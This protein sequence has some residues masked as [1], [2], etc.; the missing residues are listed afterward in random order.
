M[1]AQTLPPLPRLPRASTF[2]GILMAAL[3]QGIRALTVG[4]SSRSENIV[5]PL[6]VTSLSRQCL[7][8]MGRR[9][10]AIAG[11]RTIVR[12]MERHHE[13]AYRCSRVGHRACQPDLRSDRQQ[14]E[15]WRLRL[16][17]KLPLLWFQ[18]IT[19]FGR[20]LRFKPPRWLDDAAGPAAG[21]IVTKSIIAG[22]EGKLCCARVTLAGRH[23][24]IC[25][26][27]LVAS[28]A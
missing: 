11:R 4:L 9:P 15:L 7:Q 13:S 3:N 6:I 17:A 22:P 10:A 20:G 19:L 1:T 12:N 27:L 24:R 18:S 21:R 25:S 16:G 14:S 8:G 28:R 5:H 26:S 2:H 23:E